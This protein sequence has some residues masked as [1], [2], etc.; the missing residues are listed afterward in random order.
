MKRII[1]TCAVL[2]L[3][4]AAVYADGLFGSQAA[5]VLGKMFNAHGHFALINS[6][7][8]PFTCATADKGTLYFNTGS[9]AVKTCDGTTWTFVPLTLG[10]N[11]DLT[12]S[13]ATTF[14]T[15]NVASGSWAGGEVSYTI[16][17][18][19]GTDHQLRHS[20]IKYAAVNKAGTLTCGI[21]TQDGT[22][23]TTVNETTDGNAV[24]ISSGTLT[25][26]I[27]CATGTNLINIKANA[28][29]SLTQ[30]SLRAYYRA[31]LD[32]VG[33]ITGG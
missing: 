18:S 28:V 31:T 17:A 25:Y 23:G 7:S 30:T 13:T 27:T 29:S 21:T 20:A 14:V 4:A 8:D 10:S 3:L 19:N 11:K 2:G 24:A 22:A 16:E 9:S 32:G 1:A 12:E 26:A 5:Y 15:I 6:A 33:S